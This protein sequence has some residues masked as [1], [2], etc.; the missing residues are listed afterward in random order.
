MDLNKLAQVVDIFQKYGNHK[1]KKTQG[2]VNTS[3]MKEVLQVHTI[4]PDHME[5]THIELL[6]H[7]GVT[8]DIHIG[9]WIAE[10]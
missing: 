2:Y 1:I 9:Q 10:V 7:C 8:W 5:E 6:N 3:D 4:K